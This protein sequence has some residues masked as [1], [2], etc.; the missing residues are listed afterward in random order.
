MAKR[1]IDETLA[2]EIGNLGG[3]NT[4]LGRLKHKAAYGEKEDLN[5]QEQES[6]N[7][8]LNRGSQLRSAKE[9]QELAE[10]SGGWAWERSRRRK[11][12]RRD[13]GTAHQATP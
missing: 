2:N 8:F 1:D 6:L 9:D 7:R 11:R 3:E 12:C 10:I 5:Q 13:G 4:G